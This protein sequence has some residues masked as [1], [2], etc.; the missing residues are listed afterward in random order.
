[1]KTQVLIPSP[2]GAIPARTIFAAGSALRI[3][4]AE[5]RSSFA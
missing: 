4:A 3:V 2:T 5:A 1:M